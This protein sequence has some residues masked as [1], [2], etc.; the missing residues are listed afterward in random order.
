MAMRE[1]LAFAARR[2]WRVLAV[3][4]AGFA[5]LTASGFAGDAPISADLSDVGFF[6]AHAAEL[7]AKAIPRAKV[8]IKA[9]L[10]LSIDVPGRGLHSASLDN[11]YSF[12]LRNPAAC[13]E[14]L[15]THVASM[16]ASF[17]ASREIE[18]SQLRA[19]VRSAAMVRAA[20]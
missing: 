6:T 16:A 19:I 20:D 18:R 1:R 7:F 10:A 3:L 8:E 2:G 11:V 12:C 5:L 4:P 9:P 15:V 17:E 13:E 14:G